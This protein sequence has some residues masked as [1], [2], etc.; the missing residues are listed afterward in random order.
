MAWSNP[1]THQPAA[2]HGPSIATARPRAPPP[3]P[4][5]LASVATAPRPPCRAGS[6][7]VDRPGFFVPTIFRVFTLDQDLEAISRLCGE[8]R[9]ELNDGRGKPRL[10]R[11]RVLNRLGTVEAPKR[12]RSSERGWRHAPSTTAGFRWAG[13]GV[14]AWPRPADKIF[15]GG[16]ATM[17]V[18]PR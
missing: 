15:S 13:S 14:S 18:W 5:R 10:E 8:R 12:L 17:S 3:P 7:V 2:N 16:W 4:A 1:A 9:K 11:V 6:P